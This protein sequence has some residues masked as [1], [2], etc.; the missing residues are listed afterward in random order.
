ML[1]MNVA[2]S[3]FALRKKLLAQQSQAALPSIDQAKAAEV[4]ISKGASG[5]VPGRQEKVTKT[6]ATRHT[7]VE[8]RES[9]PRLSHVPPNQTPGEIAGP[10]ADNLGLVSESLSAPELDE[11]EG[12][13]D[14]HSPAQPINFST[15]RPSKGKLRKTSSGVCRLKLDEGDRLVILGSYGI[16]VESG[17]LT[18]YGATLG[19]SDGVSWVHAPQSHAL[20][21]IRCTDDATLELYPHPGAREMKALSLLSPLF[22]KVW[23]ESPSLSPQEKQSG[24]SETFRI[25][26]T[27]EDGPKKVTL[28]DLKSPPEWNREI[29]RL[30]APKGRVPSSTMITGPKASGKSTFGKILTNRLLTGTQTRNKRSNNEGVIVLDLDPGQP[31][32]CSAG[33]IALVLV[34]KP[35]L[36]PSFCRPLDAPDVRTIRSHALASLSPASDPELYIEMALDLI[37]HYRNA[38]GSYPLVINT[39]GWIQGTGLDLLVSLVTELR[40]SE[41]IYMSQTGPAD[42]VEALGGACNATRFLTLPSQPTQSS[43]RSAI[44]L[45]S[46][47]T[48]SYFHAEPIAQPANGNDFRWF[49]K[50]LTAITPWQ[51]HFRGASRAIFG[52]M[53]YDFQ[54]QPDLVADAINGTILAVVE[55]ES[56]KAFR[57]IE[58]GENMRNS[59]EDG[60]VPGSPMELDSSE[61]N[62]A[63]SP[64][65]SPLQQSIITLTAEGIPFIDTSHGLTLDPRYSRSLGLVLVRGIDVANGDLHLLSPITTSQIE[66]VRA[67]GG[68]IVLVS[69]KFD[70]PSW[71]YTEDLYYQS[72]DDGGDGQEGID[73][74]SPAEGTEVDPGNMRRDGASFSPQNA[75]S[76]PW[77]EVLT[78]NQKRGAGSKVWRVR[79]DL[80][81]TGNAAD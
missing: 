76:V 20:P 53:C 41:V 17:E 46:M 70:P 39:P 15:F 60:P 43:L 35:V 11:G 63:N 21:V 9:S 24:S 58:N 14:V 81:R 1:I 67:R 25:L 2:M 26:Y 62:Q 66:E 42:A 8:P 56:V 4:S 23:L 68:Q 54:T 5:A 64:P 55:I 33:Q 47:Q 51:V 34:S 7:S 10:D 37:T 6:R 12:N 49:Q 48:M 29:A 30:V 50:P 3:A 80:G 32:Y 71:A 22:R 61:N 69:G 18:L 57:D 72:A 27:S 36:S 59:A 78:R 79:R 52:V 75:G 74:E 44:H 38:F 40:P 73:P 16:R 65:L 45:R 19:V 77:I 13:S 31:E 28:Q